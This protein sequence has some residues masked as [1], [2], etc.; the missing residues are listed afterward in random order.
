MHIKNVLAV[1]LIL[2]INSCDN[3][4][5]VA[6]EATGQGGSLTRFAIS[7]N[8]LYVA[9]NSTIQVFDIGQDTFSKVNEVAVGFGLETIVVRSEYLY[10]GARDAMY[11]YSL[12]KPADP[13]FLFRY[14]H[15]TSCDPVVVQGDRAYVTLWTQTSCTASGTNSLEIIDISNPLNPTQVASY[16]MT[17]PRGLGVNGNLLFV[18]QSGN[19]LYVY[20]ISDET[21]IQEVKVIDDIDAYD[22]IVRE[23]SLIVTGEDG[24]FQYS[25]DYDLKELQ[26]LSKITVTRDE[27]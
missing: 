7:G 16:D 12:A 15:I 9:D 10:L 14:A 18:C 22:V 26:L 23:G 3:D 11:I 6:L 24:V 8:Y 21:N 25:V 27:I 5:V 19:G 17:S 4:S 13:S 20:D 2:T 1:A